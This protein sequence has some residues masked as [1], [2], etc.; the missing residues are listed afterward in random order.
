MFKIGE[1]AIQCKSMVSKERINTEVVVTSNLMK[2][3]LRPVGEFWGHK[4]ITVDGRECFAPPG[5]LKK[6]PKDDPNS[7]VSWDEVK[8][9]CG[10][11]PKK[12]TA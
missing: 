8:K 7:T 9:V 4:F 5:Y 12:V 2:L 11:S 3:S 1:I 6:K 10:W